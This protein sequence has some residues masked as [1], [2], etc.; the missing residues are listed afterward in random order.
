M[1]NSPHSTRQYVAGM[2]A[3]FDC[4]SGLVDDRFLMFNFLASLWSLA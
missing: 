2:N 1:A 3:R 4:V